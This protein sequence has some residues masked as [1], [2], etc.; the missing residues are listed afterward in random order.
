M[1]SLQLV[2]KFVGG[3]REGVVYCALRS[4]GER[5]SEFDIT[6]KERRHTRNQGLVADSVIMSAFLFRLA[7][8]NDTIIMVKIPEIVILRNGEWGVGRFAQIRVLLCPL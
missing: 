4:H 7:Q 3:S 1:V 5:V 6:L 8:R 2:L